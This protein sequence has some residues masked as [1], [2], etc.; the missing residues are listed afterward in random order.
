MESNAYQKKISKNSLRIFGAVWCVIL[1]IFGYIY[2]YNS[3]VL[4]FSVFFLVSACFFPSLYTRVYLYQIWIKFGNWIGY[5]NS[6]IIIF[7]L[8]YLMFAPL[9]LFLRAMGKDSLKKKLDKNAISYFEDR[10]TDPGSMEKQ[11]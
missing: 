6:R 4:G 2:D 8:F 1:A 9:G 7:L 5:F 3:I 11:Y 10:K